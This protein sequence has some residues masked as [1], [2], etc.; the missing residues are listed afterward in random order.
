MAS[1]SAKKGLKE[2][3][4]IMNHVIG[5]SALKPGERFCQRFLE[6]SFLA[7]AHIATIFCHCCAIE[8]QFSQ[9]G[10]GLIGDEV[11]GVLYE[12][13]FMHT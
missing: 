11:K 13:F 8:K 1:T 2:Q 9:D 6:I 4:C 7:K 5:I 10:K 3:K 12:Q